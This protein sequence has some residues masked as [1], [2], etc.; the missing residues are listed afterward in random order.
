T[1]RSE[2]KI[3]DR[4]FVT[5]RT[6]RPM[7]RPPVTAIIHTL[8]ER[9]YI[10]ACIASVEWADEIYLVDSFSTDGTVEFVKSRFPR[11]RIEQREYLG[12]ASQKNF[13]IDRTEH[14]WIY[15]I[16]AD[17]RVTPK[18]KEE[19]LRTLDGD[20]KHWAYAVGS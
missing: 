17:E 5:E 13:A 7:P 19:I 18:L 14:D 11:V 3:A 20:S 16:D 4:R 12:A 6:I 8:N 2:L 1:E 9:D 15:Y 10:E